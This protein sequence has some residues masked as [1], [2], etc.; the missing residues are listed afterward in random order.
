MWF[1]EYAV[2]GEDWVGLR[3]EEAGWKAGE[4]GIPRVGDTP[5]SLGA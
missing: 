3:G 4:S 1:F 2:R 5:S